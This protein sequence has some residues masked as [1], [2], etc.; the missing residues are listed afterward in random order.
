MQMISF[1]IP[2]YRS[3]QTIE[4]VVAEIKETMAKLQDKSWELVLVNDCSPDD[5][6]SVIRKLC[7]ENDNITGIDFARNFGQHSALMAGMRETKG[8]VVICLDDDGQTPPSEC[9]KLLKALED[10]ADAAYAKYGNKKHSPFRNFGS[11]VNEKMAEFMLDK[12]K[13]LHLSSYFAAKRFVIDEMLR[14]ENS[15]PYIMGLVLRATRNIV[16]VQVEHRSRTV[17]ES[18]YSLGKLLGLWMN[19]FTS[20]SVKPLRIATMLG[21]FFALTGF[22]YGIVIIIQHFILPDRVVGFASIISLIAFFGGMVMIML[23]LI[24]EYI[25]R[26]YIC[27]NASPQYVIKERIKHEKQD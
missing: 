21:V 25:G 13:E 16:N 14:Y 3:E 8:D 9:P 1:V 24:G 10:G 5:T 19:G 18:G 11:Y 26:I 7:S 22:I 17:G 6:M 20:F 27:M 15:Y 12:P 23:G 4:G 2:C